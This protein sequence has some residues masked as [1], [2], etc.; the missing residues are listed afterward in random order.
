MQLNYLGP[1]GSGEGHPLVAEI[2]GER[3]PASCYLVEVRDGAG[4]AG[5][6][7]E[8]DVLVVDEARP[9]Q[10]ADLVVVETGEGLGLFLSHRVGGRFRLVPAG[11]GQGH[12]ARPELCRGVVVRQARVW[13]A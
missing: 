8:G 12:K 10:H 13:A 2:A 9:M 11:G 7:I 1:M 3:F 6:I 4:V 5:P